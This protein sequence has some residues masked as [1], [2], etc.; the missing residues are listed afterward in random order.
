MGGG[1]VV[2]DNDAGFGCIVLFE[3]KV[4]ASTLAAMAGDALFRVGF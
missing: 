4:R 2:R 1:S 3:V